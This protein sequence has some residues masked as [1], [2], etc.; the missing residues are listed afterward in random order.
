VPCGP[1]LLTKLLPL[2]LEGSYGLSIGP[3][4]VDTHVGQLL[5]FDPIINLVLQLLITC[6]L[7]VEFLIID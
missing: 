1:L 7:V 6:Q 3:F 2:H 5:S 4:Q